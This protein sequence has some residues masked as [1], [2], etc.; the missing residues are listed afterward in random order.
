[1]PFNFNFFSVILNLEYQTVNTISWETS[2]EDSNVVNRSL[3][4]LCECKNMSARAITNSICANFISWAE[5]K[6]F[7]YYAFHL[8]SVFGYLIK[9]IMHTIERS[10]RKNLRTIQNSA[11]LVYAGK[12]YTLAGCAI[13]SMRAH[14][15]GIILGAME[16]FY[17]QRNSCTLSRCIALSL[18]YS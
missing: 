7:T 5:F 14:K 12:K 17:L 15:T 6:L 18:H 3:Q 2:S 11:V 1:M 4:P 13:L 8:H 16:V 9:L 10:F